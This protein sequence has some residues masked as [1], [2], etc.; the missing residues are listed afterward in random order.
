MPAF[1][2]PSRSWTVMV[3]QTHPMFERGPGPARTSGVSVNEYHSGSGNNVLVF[4][5]RRHAHVDMSGERQISIFLFNKMAVCCAIDL[6]M[7]RQHCSLLVSLIFL[8]CMLCRYADV[9]IPLYVHMY[10]RVE[11]IHLLHG[12][13]G[14]IHSV[15][16]WSGPC[17]R[18]EKRTNETGVL[19]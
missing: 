10:S 12:R 14:G 2:P 19:V 8:L 17:P 5:W 4:K 13:I 1:P 11:Y 6:P 16:P 18:T 9:Y 7:A 3:P 15:R